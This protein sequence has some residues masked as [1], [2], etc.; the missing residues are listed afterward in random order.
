MRRFGR[1]HPSIRL[2]LGEAV[3]IELP[4]VGT[5]GYRWHPSASSSAVNVTRRPAEE[6]PTPLAT[7]EAV[8]EKF[9]LIATASGRFTIE[10][11][12]AR[13]WAREQVLDRHRVEIIVCG[14]RSQTPG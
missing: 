7:G 5:S 1:S 12:R 8:P 6:A 14:S 2:E 3:E 10:F 11:E 13:P 4:G 9:E